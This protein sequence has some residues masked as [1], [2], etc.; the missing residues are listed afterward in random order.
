MAFHLPKLPYAY[1]ALAPHVSENTLHYHHD[2]HHRTYVD[3]LNELVEGTELARKPLEDVILAAAKDESKKKIFNNAAQHWNHAVFWLCMS[4]GG[5]EPRGELREKIDKHFGS[6]VKFKET[7][8][9]EGVEQFGSGWVWLVEDGG[10]LLIR[11][12]HDAM[13]PLV[14]GQRVLM[15]CDV[16]EH[17]YYLDYKNEREKFLKA[18]IDNLANWD[19]ATSCLHFDEQEKPRKTG[20]R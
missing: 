16:W 20:T 17:A 14:E 10:K 3:K 7:F 1:D 19:Y 9:H 13:T 6:F 12:T 11:A 8:V 18:F 2:K 4:P 5:G 15:T